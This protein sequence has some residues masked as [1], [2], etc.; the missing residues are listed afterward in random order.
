VHA[1]A[2]QVWPLQAVPAPKV[3][4]AWQ[5]ATLLPEHVVWPGAHTPVHAPF[6][7]VWLLHA[8]AVLQVPLEVHVSTPLP[9]QVV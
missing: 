3:P 9:E 5:V 8:V 6:R 7:H 4:F 1:P 2:T